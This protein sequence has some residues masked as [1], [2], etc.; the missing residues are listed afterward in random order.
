MK[1]A[2]H[3]SELIVWQLAEQIRIIVFRFTERPQFNAD[4]KAR[5]QAD[6][7]VNSMTRNIAEGFGCETHAEFARFLE[8]SR[9]SFN[10]LHD[11]LRGAELKKYVSA[12]E[13][14]PIR[15]LSKR[16]YPAYSRLISYLKRTPNRRPRRGP[17]LHRDVNL[18]RNPRNKPRTDERQA[19][20]TDERQA[21]R[22]DDRRSDR[23]DKRREART[24]DRRSA[25]TD[26]D[27]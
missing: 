11:V 17:A 20:R 16:L 9:R 10:E 27:Q 26:K 1:P 8:I 24:D 25:R 19:P 13:L 15:Q 2:R 22:T 12:S 21:P 6:D 14:A 4:L 7:S 18:E 23:T 5:G 3:Y